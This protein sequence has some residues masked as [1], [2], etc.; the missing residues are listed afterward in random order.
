MQ[1]YIFEVIDLADRIRVPLVYIP[2]FDVNEIR[3]VSDLVETARILKAC[4]DYV[5]GR[6]I[7]VASENTLGV[8]DNLRLLN[9]VDHEKMRIMI[10]TYNPII[11]GHRTVNLITELWPYLCDQVHVKDGKNN[12]MGNARLGEGDAEFA[13]VIT[14]LKGHGFDGTLIIENEY[15]PSLIGTQIQHDIVQIELLFGQKGG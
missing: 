8:E 10:D 4:C 11:W 2:S 5:G 3:N 1:D 15:S 14:A 13:E 9:A 7:E 6:S 12:T